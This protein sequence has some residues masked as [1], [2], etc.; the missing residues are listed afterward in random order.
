MSKN[1]EI[2]NVIFHIDGG[3]G[4]NIL[5]T[6]VV[7]AIKRKYAKAKIIV[8]CGYPDVF[9]ENKNVHKSLAFSQATNVY[10]EYILG[11]KVKVF[12]SDPYL[13]SDFITEE[14]NLIQIWC[15]LIGVDYNN[16]LPEIFLSKA[17]IDYYTPFYQT[18]KP[19]LTIHANGG[20][21]NQP[22]KYSWTR[23]IPAYYVNELIEKYKHQYTIVQI[24]R[25]DQ[26]EYKGA[27]S[28]LDGWRSIAV[29]LSLSSKR[30][31]IDSSSMHICAA[32]NL[33]STVLWIGTN[34]KVLGYE[35]HNNI[36]ANK[37]T[38]EINLEHN[39]YQKNLFFQDISTFPYNN[40]EEMFDFDLIL[41]SLK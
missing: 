39:F 7:K 13:T 23:D 21:E 27:L 3:L 37:P 32:L 10:N 28:A 15:E 19:I 24:R 12:N 18:P 1:Q 34:P 11:K 40:F 41:N 14:K 8:V 35:I 29:L 17:E 31:L 2:E 38:K 9:V 30:I 33:P 36:V 6:A 5:A 4:K 20:A 25:K 26:I 16:E 22:L